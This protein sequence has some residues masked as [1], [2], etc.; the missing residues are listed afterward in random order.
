MAQ[1]DDPHRTDADIA[2]LLGHTDPEPPST[3]DIHTVVHNGR[4]R[5]RRR[6]LF[7]VAGVTAAAAVITAAVPIVLS[8]NGVQRDDRAIA[9]SPA[10]SSP[11]PA[12]PQPTSPRPPTTCTVSRL[13]E[14]AGTTQSYVTAADP[15]G[16]YVAARIYGSG[17]DMRLV[18]WDNGTLRQVYMPGGDAAWEAVNSH[19]TAVGTS[20][21]GQDT[22]RAWIYRDG[23][24]NRLAGNHAR[25]LGVSE[26]GDVVGVVGR[27]IDEERPVIWRGGT[28]NPIP[29]RLPPGYSSG[30]AYDVSPDGH[31]VGDVVRPDELGSRPVRWRPDGSPLLLPV[32]KDHYGAA[33]VIRGDWIAGSG[34]ESRPSSIGG[35]SQTSTILRW[36]LRT[37]DVETMAG[38]GAATINEHGWL[39]GVPEVGS[40][41]IIKSDRVLELPKFADTPVEPGNRTVVK[42]F[43][44]DGRFLAGHLVGADGQTRAVVWRCQ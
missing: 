36:N 42:G 14:P 24:V 17:R 32:P 25:A 8:T 4:R 9:G 26:N 3:V 38:Y 15:T 13:P 12:S 43:T 44:Q 7:A 28:G 6:R 11:P 27:L 5:V 20:Y 16:R 39:V 31:I 22:T 35:T 41:P 1:H 2:S 23:K 21:I 33:Q 34:T 10:P 19:G 29:L 37:G 40:A 18:L 30:H